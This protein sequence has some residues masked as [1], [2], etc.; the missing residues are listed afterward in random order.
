MSARILALFLLVTALPAYAGE[1][2]EIMPESR[3]G[4]WDWVHRGLGIASVTLLG[5]GA[6]FT[7]LAYSELYSVDD[8]VSGADRVAINNRID[9]YNTA[10]VTCYCVA[11]ATLV[12]YLVWKLWPAEDLQ[13]RPG[14]GGLQLQVRF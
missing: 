6:T 10:A 1:M 5:A 4:D 3:T 7:A 2:L 9:D 14:P 8:T 13:V 12:V 11:A